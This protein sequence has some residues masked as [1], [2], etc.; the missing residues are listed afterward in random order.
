MA[1]AHKNFAK[2]VVATAPAPALSGTTLVVAAGDGAKFPTVPFN[3]TIWPV[4]TEPTT[5]NA[6][7]V[8]VT[9]VATDTLTITRAQETSPART[10]L[11]GDQIMAGVTAKTL[12]DI[13]N[14]VS[15]TIQTSVVT[16]ASAGLFYGIC[17]GRL[18]ATSGTAV[19]T[20]D[21]TGATSL[22]F[23]P[24]SP[25][26]FAGNIGLYDGSTNWNILPFAELTLALG[27]ITS[28]LPYD[29][30]AYNNSGAVALRAPVAW[31]N[32]TTRAT[33]LVLQNGVWVKTGA[34]TDRYL[35]TFYTTSTTQTEDSIAKRYVWNYYNRVERP[36][37][38]IETT[39]SWAYQSATIRQANGSTSN[40]V[41]FV[42]GVAEVLFVGTVACQAQSAAGGAAISIGLVLDSTTT[43]NATAGVG[44]HWLSNAAVGDTIGV[45]GTIRVYP[46]VGFHFAS[47]NERTAAA[48]S[49]TIFSND[50][51]S[52]LYSGITASICG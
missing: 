36:M 24:Y 19:T 51:G 12:T 4:N 41:N 20:A 27:T 16:P 15:P 11:V 42:V 40:Q 47:W 34:T 10:V 44:G 43:F 7:I 17:G 29:V 49:T 26:G 50:N 30:F 48:Q 21:V 6:E 31:T 23:T 13:E 3:A 2:T 28:G 39:N 5:A 33:A 9:T 38:R 18:T 1:D 45:V 22:F 46:A 32:G 37:I 25:W 14:G 35:G 52:H 8:R